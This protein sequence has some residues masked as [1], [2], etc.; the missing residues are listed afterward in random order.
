MTIGE[1]HGRNVPNRNNL[2]KFIARRLY[3]K[4]IGCKQKCRHLFLISRLRLL[5]LESYFRETP[6]SVKEA[7]EP[8]GSAAAPLDHTS[9]VAK[10]RSLNRASG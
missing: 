7:S 8:G 4:G 10:S 9:N 1:Y 5:T 3:P 2:R 6:G